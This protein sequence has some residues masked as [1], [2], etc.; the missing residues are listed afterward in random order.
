MSKTTI[1]E[2]PAMVGYRLFFALAGLSA[3]ALIAV[4]NAFSRSAIPLENYFSATV[5]HA[6]EMLFGYG[7]AVLA[8]LLLTAVR[9]LATGDHAIGSK[10]VLGLALIWLYGRVVPFYAG[11]LPDVLIALLDLAFLP[12]LA[13]Y[14]AKIVWRAEDKS[15]WFYPFLVLVL[16]TANMLV[17]VE[18]LG[19]ADG[20]ATL[21]VDLF[22][23]VLV[24][25]II[26]GSGHWIPLLTERSLSGV[27]CIR[28]PL[29]DNLSIALALLAWL[30]V[31]AEWSG[32]WLMALCIMACLANALRAVAWFDSRVWFV[33]LLWILYLGYGWLLLG[34]LLLALSGFSL[35]SELAAIHA[36]AVGGI[37]VLSLGMMARLV[38]GTVGRSARAANLMAISFLLINGAVFLLVLLPVVLP[39]WYAEFLVVA[40]Y[41]WLAAFSLFM[42]YLSP[43]FAVNK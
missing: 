30:A 33:P 40:A 4:W 2:Y 23:A 11:L 13:F 24:M 10:Q 35:V 3:L 17:H 27:I 7:V 16:A 1:F 39:D 22:V 8:G 15:N 6:H 36:F 32:G 21:G 31:L 12:M 43:V 20:T 34:F 25:T 42:V 14:L 5:W 29:L 26:L 41:L 18:E 28:N 19:L 37:G 38:V 9:S